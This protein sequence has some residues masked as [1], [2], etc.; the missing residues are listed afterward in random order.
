MPEIPEITQQFEILN[1]KSGNQE[2]QI[3]EK[4]QLENEEIWDKLVDNV[5]LTSFWYDDLE[6]KF[7]EALNKDKPRE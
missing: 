7:L 3:L 4:Y 5:I 2:A 1:T 6:E